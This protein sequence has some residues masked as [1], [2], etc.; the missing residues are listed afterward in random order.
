VVPLVA[1][2][3]WGDR[4]LAPGGPP[5]VVEHGGCGGDAVA[6]LVCGDC[7][8]TLGPGDVHSHPGPGSGPAAS[9]A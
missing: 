5:R 9:P 2:M 7:G 6:Q 4:H 3:Q 1:I 8:A